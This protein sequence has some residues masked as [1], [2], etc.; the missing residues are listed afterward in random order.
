MSVLLALAITLQ[1]GSPVQTIARDMMS[2]VDAPAQVVARTSAEWTDLWRR[3]TGDVAAPKVDFGTR[4]VVAV[5]LGTR[6]TAGFAVEITAAREQGG[7][8]I[9][10]WR[11]TRP[12]RDTILAQVLTSPAHIASIPKFAGEI[13]FQKVER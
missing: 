4:A 3:H 12:S 1:A 8:L 6:P 11:E 5:F 13:T 2:Q 10:E 7:V 9:V